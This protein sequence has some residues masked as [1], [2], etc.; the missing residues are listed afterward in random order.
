[1][2]QHRE[3]R[4]EVESC[5]SLREGAPRASCLGI[6]G[7]AVRT[8]H[9]ESSQ[10]RSLV[11]P[12]AV[13][14]NSMFSLLCFSLLHFVCLGGDSTL[15]TSHIYKLAVNF[16]T[17]IPRVFTECYFWLIQHKKTTHSWSN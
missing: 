12:E 8:R 1:M 4:H 10:A 9:L 11:W 14:E 7:A 15:R 6:R 17:D 13:P 2:N 16:F 3:W 5:S